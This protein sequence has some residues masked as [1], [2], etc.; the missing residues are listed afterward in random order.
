M[1]KIS[2]V[3]YENE[4][5]KNKIVLDLSNKDINTVSEINKL[6]ETSNSLI[7]DTLDLSHNLL[8]N[9]EF[10]V[11][12]IINIKFC[13]TLILDHNNLNGLKIESFPRSIK[14]LSCKFNKITK[15]EDLVC[16]NKIKT[17]QEI[18]ISNNPICNTEIYRIH[19]LSCMP[20]LRLIN[21]VKVSKDERRIN[22]M[23]MKMKRNS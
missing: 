20:S 16:R 7:Y 23:K 22:K 2:P 6:I 21:E 5:A 8:T 13:S 19:L 17:L 1:D 3:Y 9:N 15:I 4:K 10:N 12:R 14:K 11:N 18:D